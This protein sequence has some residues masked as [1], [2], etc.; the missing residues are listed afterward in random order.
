[1]DEVNEFGEPIKK[2]VECGFKKPFF[3]YHYAVKECI[4]DSC[5]MNRVWGSSDSREN[6]RRLDK[7]ELDSDDYYN[8]VYEQGYRC[9]ICNKIPK[10]GYHIDHDHKTGKVRGLLCLKCNI[11]LGCFNDDVNLFKKCIDYLKNHLHI[12]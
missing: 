5:L 12:I 6:K 7:Y 8:M 1:M 10:K 3:H 9:K 4:C 2:C 11:G